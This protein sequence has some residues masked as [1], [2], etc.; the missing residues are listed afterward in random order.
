MPA[1]SIKT[2]SAIYACKDMFPNDVTQLAQQIVEL[3]S[4]RPRFSVLDLDVLAHRKVIDS[5][6]AA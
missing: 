6:N 1:D 2:V 3:N 4:T 5:S